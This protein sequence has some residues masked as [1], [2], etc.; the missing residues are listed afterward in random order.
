[1]N[2][3]SALV[4]YSGGKAF[5]FGDLFAGA[6]FGLRCVPSHRI[7]FTPET[8]PF[9]RPVD[10]AIFTSRNSVQALVRTGLPMLDHVEIYAVGESTLEAL[11]QKG[12]FA[13][14]PPE[15]PSAESILKGLPKDLTGEFIFWPRGND[16]DTRLADEL[17]RRGAEVYSPVVYEKTPR[18]LPPDLAA[19][20]RES[21]YK[22]FACTSASAARWLFGTLDEEERRRLAATPAVVLGHATRVA[23]ENLGAADVTLARETRFESLAEALIESLRA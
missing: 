4:I 19:E 5:E 3:P 1:V 11:A 10:R 18:E 7:E 23:L 22:V 17:A 13:A 6:G 20:I 15:A 9:G 16:S 8:F 12:F 2:P 21:R 14:A